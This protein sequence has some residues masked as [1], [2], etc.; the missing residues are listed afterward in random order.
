M[1][2]KK[3]HSKSKQRQKPGRKISRVAFIIGFLILA[4]FF[5]KGENGFLKYFQLQQEKKKLLQEIEELKKENENLRAEIELLINN[6]RYI[7]KEA[8]ETHYMGKED[9]K[10]YI[11]NSTKE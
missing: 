8:R 3:E 11:M 1:A 4:Y 10:I 7:E 9:E 5:L 6:F 2:V